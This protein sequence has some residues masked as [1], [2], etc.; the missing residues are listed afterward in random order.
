MN[1]L[2]DKQFERFGA[3]EPPPHPELPLQLSDSSPRNMVGDL[4]EDV[5]DTLH[6]WDPDTRALIW[7]VYLVGVLCG[8]QE[9]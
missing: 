7:A 6:Q 1:Y 5:E 9:W 8:R 4:R 2:I 3:G